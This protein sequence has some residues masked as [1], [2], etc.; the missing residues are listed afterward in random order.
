MNKDLIDIDGLYKS[1]NFIEVIEKT[2]KLIKKGQTSVAYYNLLG[3]SLDNIGK[4]DEAEKYF[5]EAIKINSE[6]I[7]HYSNL[8]KIL[9]KKVKLMMQKKYYNCHRNTK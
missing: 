7:S 1:G 2:K 3:I 8:A 9:L 5:N 4:S 6:E